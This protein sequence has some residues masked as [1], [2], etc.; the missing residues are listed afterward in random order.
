M[1]AGKTTQV[2]IAPEIGN[3]IPYERNPVRRVGEGR[4]TL[5]RRLDLPDDQL[6][7]GVLFELGERG[8]TDYLALPIGGVHAVDCMMTFV[9]DQ[10]GGFAAKRGGGRGLGAPVPLLRA[11]R[12]L[13]P[14]RVRGR[15]SG[16]C[17]L[18]QPGL[19]AE[20]SRTLAM[21]CR[22]Y[23]SLSTSG[24]S[25]Q[26][27]ALGTRLYGHGARNWWIARA[28]INFLASQVADCID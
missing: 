15:R 5:H 2:L 10:P 24:G 14:A 19:R 28:P 20:I 12:C 17:D 1:V 25:S 7:F 16:R 22:P 4:E 6:D 26:G 8:G 21:R 13:R 18:R 27:W 3:A 9:T 11:C 23:R